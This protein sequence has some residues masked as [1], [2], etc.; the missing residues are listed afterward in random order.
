M[1]SGLEKNV[2]LQMTPCD[3]QVY[4]LNLLTLRSITTGLRSVHVFSTSK[5]EIHISDVLFLLEKNQEVE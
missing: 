2:L 1:G 5:L 4:R 3:R